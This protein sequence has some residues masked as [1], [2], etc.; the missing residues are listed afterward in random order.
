MRLGGRISNTT[1]ISIRV[2]VH[3]PTLRRRRRGRCPANAR[4]ANV[5][6]DD[7]TRGAEAIAWRAQTQH[8][9]NVPSRVRRRM[10]RCPGACR[11]ARGS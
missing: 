2:Y 7:R 5:D 11:H 6:A 9:R 1:K 8:T 4:G 3:A 10:R